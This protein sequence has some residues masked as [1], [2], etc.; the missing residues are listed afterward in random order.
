MAQEAAAI[1]SGGKTEEATFTTAL[2]LVGLFA[3]VSG[4]V[5]V[6]VSCQVSVQ[7]C[8]HVY[9]SA[10]TIYTSRIPQ[11]ETA[12]IWPG[13][14]VRACLK[15]VHVLVCLPA[16]ES[17]WRVPQKCSWQSHLPARRSPCRDAVEMFSNP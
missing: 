12:M 13:Y 16:G 3:S 2:L 11:D 8:I 7:P 5:F 14:R 4:S 15:C 6:L 9:L 10:F 1:L 17:L